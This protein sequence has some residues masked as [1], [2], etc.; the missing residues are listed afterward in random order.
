MELPDLLVEIAEYLEGH[1]DVMDGAEGPRP[2]DA[3]WLLQQLEPFLP[4]SPTGDLLPEG[5]K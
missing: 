5:N 3:M 2:N 1:S 4:P